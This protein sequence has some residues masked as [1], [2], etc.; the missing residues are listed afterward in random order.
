MDPQNN[1]HMRSIPVHGWLGLIMI[2]FA[3]IG[4][5]TFLG[6]R[7]HI[8]FFPQWLGYILALDGLVVKRKGHS[9][10]TRNSEFF[11][12]LFL[13]SM[14]V[15]WVFEILNE[16]TQN[17]EYI[18]KD[19]FHPLEY[20]ILSSLSF[21]TVIPAIVETAE[22]F[23]SFPGIYNMPQKVKLPQKHTLT[24]FFVSG[25]ILL[26]LLFI[27]PDYFFPAIWVAPFMIIDPVNA[28]KG[29]ESLIKQ[30]QAG[31]W[32]TLVSLWA[33]ALC[34]GFFWEMWNFYSFP[35]W[36]YHVPHVGF[37]KI[38]EMPVLGYLG[39]LPFSLELFAII[40]LV[41]KISSMKHFKDAEIV[42]DSSQN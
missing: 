3:W 34:C 17:W 30:A 18:G 7:T 12:V 35:K 28:W 42:L 4:N 9:L 1:Q 23:G 26:C 21:S 37:Y 8:L 6:I 16:V 20:F 13:L 38:F 41:F 32:R 19:F 10:L 33:G 15:W 39:Y 2:A 27:K 40:I 22:L 11:L 29:R 24:V 31:D 14:P 36:T 25:F 5:W